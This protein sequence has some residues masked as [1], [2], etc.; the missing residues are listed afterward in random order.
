MP[1]TTLTLCVLAL[2]A[3]VTVSKSV[4]L[5]RSA[6]PVPQEEVTLLLASDSIPADCERVAMLHGSGPDGYTDEGDMW[7]KLRDEAGKLGANAVHMQ[8]MEDPGGG[9]RFASA[10]FGTQADREPT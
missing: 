1:R 7:N 9:E 6:H 2:A 10:L 5:D 3:C 4:L 8:S